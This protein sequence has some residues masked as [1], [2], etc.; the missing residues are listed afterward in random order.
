MM[1]DEEMYVASKNRYASVKTTTINEELGQVEYIFSDKTG[2]LTCNKME[3]KYCMI[4]SQLYGEKVDISEENKDLPFS[5]PE[6][7]DI[8]SGKKVTEIVNLSLASSDKKVKLLIKTHKDLVYYFFELLASA[9][10]CLVQ[11][12]KAG[13]LFYQGKSYL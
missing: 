5:D 12:D 3:F 7:S 2:T 11:K 9:H 8:I 1:K 10:E 6:L 4:G 13:K